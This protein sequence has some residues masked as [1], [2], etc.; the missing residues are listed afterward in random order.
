MDAADS[1]RDLPMRCLAMPSVA[2][3][4]AASAAAAG[5]PAMIVAQGEWTLSQQ[6]DLP[7]RIYGYDLRFSTACIA[8]T[9]HGE[10]TFTVV[11]TPDEFSVYD[12]GVAS[13]ALQPGNQTVKVSFGAL[14]MVLLDAE[15]SGHRIRHIIE[16]EAGGVASVRATL[17]LRIDPAVV[18]LDA[19]DNLIAEFSSEGLQEVLS[20]ALECAAL[21]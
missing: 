5:E 2:L 20:R 14:E 3:T 21:D 18:V 6:T 8:E 16:P 19:A 1:D 17:K 4:L 13:R 11:V 7:F 9:R 10:D 12:I 15:V